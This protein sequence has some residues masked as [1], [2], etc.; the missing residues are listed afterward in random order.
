MQHG[1]ALMTEVALMEAGEAV[2]LIEEGVE[3]TKTPFS[4][5][6]T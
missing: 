6:S 2:D 5:E 1:L 4:F 3:D